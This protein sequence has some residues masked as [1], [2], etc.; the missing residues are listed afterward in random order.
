MRL[1]EQAWACVDLANKRLDKVQEASSIEID[2][3]IA[4]MGL[5]LL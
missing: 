1:S 4:D 2:N 3:T 5:I